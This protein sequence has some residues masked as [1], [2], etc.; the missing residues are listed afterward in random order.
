MR[1]CFVTCLGNKA[2]VGSS[3]ALPVFFQ[4]PLPFYAR[5]AGFNEIPPTAQV[6]TFAATGA[7]E[8]PRGEVIQ[9]ASAAASSFNGGSS[10]VSTDVGASTGADVPKGMR[11]GDTF[12]LGDV[13]LVEILKGMHMVLTHVY[14]ALEHG[15]SRAVPSPGRLSHVAPAKQTQENLAVRLGSL[16]TTHSTVHVVPLLLTGLC[17][18]ICSPHDTTR[19][20]VPIGEHSFLL[21]S[22]CDAFEWIGHTTF[23][24]RCC[25]SG[26]FRI[27]CDPSL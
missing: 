25:K 9:N 15:S 2:H 27:T 23:M 24:R 18:L 22:I 1:P 13:T 14:E 19:V 12:A 4:K 8:Q 21:M 26:P 3:R 7:D 11:V 6:F 20:S 17:P 10:S 5:P 16:P